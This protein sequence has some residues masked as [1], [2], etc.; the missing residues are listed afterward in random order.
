MMD[1]SINFVCLV[2]SDFVWSEKIY[3][4]S[5]WRK[6]RKEGLDKA[7]CADEIAKVNYEEVVA[8]YRDYIENMNNIFQQCCI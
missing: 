4:A 7:F 2:A 5:F 3:L 8:N 6:N 1:C